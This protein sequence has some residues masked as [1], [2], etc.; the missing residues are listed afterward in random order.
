M[1]AEREE[2]GIKHQMI[3]AVLPLWRPGLALVQIPY[4]SKDLTLDVERAWRPEQRYSGSLTIL[5]RMERG[6][7]AHT[8]MNLRNVRV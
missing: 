7:C 2:E 4:A 1:K 6:Q 3:H 8:R 5:L